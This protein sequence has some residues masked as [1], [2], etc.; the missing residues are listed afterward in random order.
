MGL[1]DDDGIV[2]IGREAN[3]P[4]RALQTLHAPDRHPEEAPERCLF[5]LFDGGAEA[6]KLPQL[7][8]GLLQ[9]FPPVGQNQHPPPLPDLEGGDGRKDDRLAGAGRQDQQGF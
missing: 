2:I 7:V 8:G 9:E 6:G 1:V 5:R 4:G 3:E